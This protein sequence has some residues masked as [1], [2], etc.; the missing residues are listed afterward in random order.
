MKKFWISL[1]KHAA[2]VINF[3]KK[4]VLPPTEKELKLHKIQRYVK[5]V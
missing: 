4:K 2:N 5:C 3:L 1:R